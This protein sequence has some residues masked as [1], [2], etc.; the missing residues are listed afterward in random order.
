MSEGAACQPDPV[1]PPNG[2][3]SEYNEMLVRTHVGMFLT[4]MYAEA[5]KLPECPQVIE[6]R[7]R[8][9]CQRSDRCTPPAPPFMFGKEVHMHAHEQEGVC[10]VAAL[11]RNLPTVSA[12]RAK[13][14]DASNVSAFAQKLL[15]YSS[16]HTKPTVSLHIVDCD[17]T[18]HLVDRVLKTWHEA[19][20]CCT[21]S[22]DCEPTEVVDVSRY[23]KKFLPMRDRLAAEKTA[24]PR[25]PP[26]DLE[27][28]LK[29]S[30]RRKGADILAVRFTRDDHYRFTF[31]LE[32]NA[33][34]ELKSQL[35]FSDD[36]KRKYCLQAVIAERGERR[37]ACYVR[38]QKRMWHMNTMIPSD[39]T[40]EVRELA[41]GQ[42]TR[43]RVIAL[44]YQQVH[45]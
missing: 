42:S 33:A 26:T 35:S 7:K 23:Q 38:E 13:D 3:E 2:G 40:R 11:L 43:E 24:F 29:L 36:Q 1:L 10:V 12:R 34:G 25:A 16:L 6:Y 21:T 8:L 27:T 39:C 41:C 37:A 20:K 22:D 4:R 45:K 28:F 17:T 14:E 19:T 32:M 30:S 44:F 15:D 5:K 18:H 31:P 9:A